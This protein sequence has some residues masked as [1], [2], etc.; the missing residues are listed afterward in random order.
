MQIPILTHKCAYLC[1]SLEHNNFSRR[2]HPRM[3]SIKNE[4]I[5]TKINSLALSTV[6]TGANCK[7]TAPSNH[8]Q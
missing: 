7:P 2:Y 3:T 1:F 6:S 8:K 4:K 5:Q